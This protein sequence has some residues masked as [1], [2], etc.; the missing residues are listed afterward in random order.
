MDGSPEN[1]ALLAAAAM[2]G[3]LGLLMVLIWVVDRY[4]Q[5]DD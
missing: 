3:G 5:H 4:G 2:L 1:L